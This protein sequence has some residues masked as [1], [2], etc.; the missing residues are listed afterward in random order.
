MDVWASPERLKYTTHLSKQL[1]TTAKYAAESNEYGSSFEKYPSRTVD[2]YYVGS[3]KLKDPS[4]TLP[5]CFEAINI[6]DLTV[7]AIH[8]KPRQERTNND[9][10]QSLTVKKYT[11]GCLLRKYRS[12]RPHMDP[13][14]S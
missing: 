14:C 2:V 10:F 6:T 4:M 3:G 9:R 1:E 8:E 7:Q 5:K 13:N 11:D 12:E